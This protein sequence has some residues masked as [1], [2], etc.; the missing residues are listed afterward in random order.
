[1]NIDQIRPYALRASALVIKAKPLLAMVIVGLCAY[2]LA[3]AL[4]YGLSASGFQT[5]TMNTPRAANGERWAWFSGQQKIIKP[6]PTVHVKEARLNAKLLGIVQRTNGSIAI[7]DTGNNKDSKV[8]KVGDK[9]NRTVSVHAIETNRVLIIERGVISSLTMETKRSYNIS[10]TPSKPPSTTLNSLLPSK[11]SSSL[12][13]GISFT[14]T[15]NGET[16][17]R[18]GSINPKMLRGT[19]L[20]PNDVVLAA[21]GTPVEQILNSPN[22]YQN[23]LQLDN[24]DITIIRDGNEESVSINPRSL[25]PNI[26]RLIATQNR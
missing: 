8:F 9:L 2:H 4:W 11:L 13:A 1:M 19:A 3:L 23:L 10:S 18:L 12:F 15:D 21:G 22:S 25:T 17:M 14:K 16:G 26:M 20:E 24:I 5:E 7:I 6:T